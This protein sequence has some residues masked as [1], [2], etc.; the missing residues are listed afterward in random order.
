MMKKMKGKK[1]QGLKFQQLH[2][3]HA[4][5]LKEKNNFLFHQQTLENEMKCKFVLFKLL[6][7]KKF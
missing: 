3:N 1:F 5:N 7:Q 2:S 6:L 4:M